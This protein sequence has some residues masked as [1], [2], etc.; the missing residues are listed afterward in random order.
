MSSKQDCEIIFGP[1]KYPNSGVVRKEPG[2]E[3]DRKFVEFSEDKTF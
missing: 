3:S 1:K 2:V